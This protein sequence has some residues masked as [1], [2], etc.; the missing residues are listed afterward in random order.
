MI[1]RNLDVDQLADSLIAIRNMI[2]DSFDSRS[3][4]YAWFEKWDNQKEKAALTKFSSDLLV[5]LSFIPEANQGRYRLPARNQ[6]SES[7]LNMNDNFQSL[8][9]FLRAHHEIHEL[10]ENNLLLL[11]SAFDAYS[12]HIKEEIKQGKG[13]KLIS[14]YSATSSS[15]TQIESTFANELGEILS[16]KSWR[17]SLAEAEKFDNLIIILKEN[18]E[19]LSLEELVGLVNRY[20]GKNPRIKMN[21]MEEITDLWK[22]FY[23]RKLKAGEKIEFVLP[24]VLQT[25]NETLEQPARLTQPT[26]STR[27][28]QS[29]RS[30]QPTRLTQPLTPPPA[31]T[32]IDLAFTSRLIEKLSSQP[33]PM[34]LR[35]LKNF[36]DLIKALEKDRG[37]LTLEGVVK[38]VDQHVGINLNTKRLVMEEVTDQWKALHQR[39]LKTGEKIEFVLPAVL[40]SKDEPPVNPSK[41]KH[42]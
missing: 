41:P 4:F 33:W 36:D 8:R 19:R 21:V 20:V 40:Q 3:E 15:E 7:F 12:H 25:N 39:K 27:L 22:V 18:Q 24:S 5:T 26:Q 29:P 23:Q 2:I 10:Y 16:S 34:P 17:M 1:G 13:D 37:K 9:D 11:E 32:Q 31:E 28:T 38:L 35:E 30:T 14:H 42:K 6:L